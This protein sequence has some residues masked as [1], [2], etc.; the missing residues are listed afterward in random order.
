MQGRK[1]TAAHE[2]KTVLVSEGG[3]MVTNPSTY[4]DTRNGI[5]KKAEEPM[6]LT[7][8]QEGWD[9]CIFQEMVDI[10]IFKI[11]HFLSLLRWYKNDQWLP[12]CWWGE[13][14]GGRNGGA[15]RMS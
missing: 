15:R 8:A 2:T 1:T 12:E 14:E 9:I 10:W 7:S 3:Q 13:R 6:P 11:T 5:R 4:R